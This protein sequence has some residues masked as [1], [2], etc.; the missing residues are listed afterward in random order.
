MGVLTAL[1][2]LLGS[3]SA[4]TASTVADLL[5]L[6]T[7]LD[8]VLLDLQLGDDSDPAQNVERIVGRGWPVLLYTQETRGGVVARCLRAGAGGLVTK[9]EDL[10]VLA[11]PSRRCCPAART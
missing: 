6:A 8:L 3:H 11:E 2:E 10:A 5:E 1:S 4:V 9:G 7:D